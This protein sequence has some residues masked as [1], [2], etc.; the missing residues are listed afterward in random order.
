[1]INLEI[2]PLAPGLALLLTGRPV[3]PLA[4][5][6]GPRQQEV[7]SLCSACHDMQPIEQSAG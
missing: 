6:D 1:M 3:P 5:P 4:L 7:A 2:R